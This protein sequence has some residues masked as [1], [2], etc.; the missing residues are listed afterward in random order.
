MTNFG[1]S[2]PSPGLLSQLSWET[3]TGDT[4]IADIEALG[5]DESKMRYV[6]QGRLFEWLPSRD[7]H[8][9]NLASEGFGLCSAVIIRD[10]ENGGYTF[11]HAQP[12]D[13]RL[14][15]ELADMNFGKSETLFIFGK[16]STHQADIQQLLADKGIKL[17]TLQLDTGDAHFG[18]TLNMT[19]GVVSVVR[20]TPDHS[21]FQYKPFTN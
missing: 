7:D 3:Q 12:F 5:I 2:C 20:K 6:G 16:H 19:S 15:Y 10:L 17:N 21:I 1:E 8:I 4:F 18:V 13:D 14:Y 9:E 11:M